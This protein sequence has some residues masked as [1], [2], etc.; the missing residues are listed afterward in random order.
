[1]CKRK[2]LAQAGIEPD[3]PLKKKLNH[4][5]NEGLQALNFGPVLIL[6]KKRQ[7]SISFSWLCIHYT[8]CIP[9]NKWQIHQIFQKL[10]FRR[11][12]LAYFFILCSPETAL[13]FFNK[14]TKYSIKFN[15]FIT[16]CELISFTL[17]TKFY[18]QKACTYVVIEAHDKW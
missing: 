3:T 13:Q 6:I 18:F 2:S 4:C 17:T 9:L 14:Q 1:M 16:G 11:L 8:Y 7:N 15:K 5:I 12:L 10:N